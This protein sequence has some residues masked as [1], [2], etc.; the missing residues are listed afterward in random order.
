MAI[1]DYQTL[2]LPVLKEASTGVVKNRDAVSK[3]SDDFGL[4]E[5]EREA[6]LPSGIGTYI[7]NRLNWSI[8]YLVKAG[9]IERPIRGHFTITDRGSAVLAQNPDRIDNK[10]LSQYPEFIEFQQKKKA[11]TPTTKDTVSDQ[12]SDIT[13]E[14][15][16]ATAYQEISSDIKSQLL[17]KVLELSPEFFEKLIVK[18][19][20][21]MGYGGST[22]EA[23]RHLGK[24]GDGGIDGVINEDKLGLDSIYIQAKR[25]APDNSIGRPEIQKFVGSLMGESASKGVFVTTS[26]YS[27]HAIQYVET[28]PQKIILIDGDKLTDLMF[29]YNVGV[30]EHQKVEIKKIDEDFFLE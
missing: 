12:D 3:I 29:E 24:S 14:E 17:D 27:A 2:M 23:G 28:V 30:R 21:G 26:S 9:L 6:H 10:F 15:R 19:L 1:P 16:I 5:E 8:T 13:P 7:S 18:L 20:I 25:Y 11:N 22:L 4:T